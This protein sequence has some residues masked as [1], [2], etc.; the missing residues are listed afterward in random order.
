MTSRGFT[1]V[2]YSFVLKYVQKAMALKDQPNKPVQDIDFR[3]LDDE[4]IVEIR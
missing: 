3:M 4:S 1:K 2:Y